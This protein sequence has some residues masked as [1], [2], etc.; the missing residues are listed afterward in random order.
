MSQILQELIDY[1]NL[2]ADECVA[3]YEWLVG[4]YDNPETLRH[5][6]LEEELGLFFEA[7]LKQ[8]HSS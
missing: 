6:Q 1:Y 3:F 5:V 8:L 7:R 4:R 2:D